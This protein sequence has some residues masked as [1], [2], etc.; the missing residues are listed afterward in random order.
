MNK[1]LQP[2]SDL[3]N[4]FYPRTC[5]SC[6]KVLSQKETTLCLECVSDLPKTN[7]HKIEENEVFKMF[8][9]RLPINHATSYMYFT[10]KGK[11]QNILHN[12][13]YNGYQELGH[14]LGYWFGQDL[15]NS[16]YYKDIDVVIP[17]PLHYKKEKKRG[18]NQSD[19]ISKGIAEGLN[20]NHDNLSLKRI[21]HS[22]TQTKKSRYQRWENVDGI[23]AVDDCTNIKDKH[24]LLVDDV[25]TTGST[26]EACHVALNKCADI[27]LSVA[28]LAFAGI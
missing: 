6:S 1:V 26:I 24:I 8:W 25:I 10:K 17:V 9:G 2:F 11:V 21:I 22:P 28:S 18:Y 13:K 14:V 4:F 12:I 19:S 23:F 27:K 3:V 5:P 16:S 7:Y 15:K 20:A